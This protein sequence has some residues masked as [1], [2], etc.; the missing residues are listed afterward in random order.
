MELIREIYSYIATHALTISGIVLAIIATAES[1]V[2]LTPTKKDD[3]AV[4]R[5]GKWIRKAMDYVGK[6][7]PNRK[8]GGGEHPKQSEKEAPAETSTEKVES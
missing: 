3:T 5:V 6:F 4:E 8:Q 1:V 7:L 2:R